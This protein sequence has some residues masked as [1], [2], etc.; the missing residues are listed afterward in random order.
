MVVLLSK[1]D[2][3]H[4]KMSK[5]MVFMFTYNHL[6]LLLSKNTGRKWSRENA[7]T[8]VCSVTLAIPPPDVGGEGAQ[9]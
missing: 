1:S 4:E 9:G 3:S 7:Y 8:A 6:G 5:A 2:R